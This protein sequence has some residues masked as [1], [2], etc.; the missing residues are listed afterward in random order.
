MVEYRPFKAG[1][2]SSTLSG[3]TIYGVLRS[4]Q[5]NNREVAQSGQRKA[6]I[7][8]RFRVQIPTSLNF[9]VPVVGHDYGSCNRKWI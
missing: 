1:V 2:E 6:L 3:P 9:Y 8:Q 5:K 7:R 4:E